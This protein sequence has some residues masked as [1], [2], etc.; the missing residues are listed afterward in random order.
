[1]AGIGVHP[2]IRVLGNRIDRAERF[3]RLAG[4]ESPR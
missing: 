4:G 2:Q 1:V 3:Q